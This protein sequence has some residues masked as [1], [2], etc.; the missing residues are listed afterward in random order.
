MADGGFALSS[1]SRK[2]VLSGK[3]W[4]TWGPDADFLEQE[5]TRPCAHRIGYCSNALA[6]QMAPHLK[7]S[8]MICKTKWHF[9]AAKTYEVA[10][11]TFKLRS[12]LRLEKTLE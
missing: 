11:I 7:M 2:P 6:A 10:V 1:R 9:Y 8:S 3:S 12:K 4:D 5:E